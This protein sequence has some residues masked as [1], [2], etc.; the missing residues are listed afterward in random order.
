MYYV[1]KLKNKYKE[2]IGLSEIKY[3]KSKLSNDNIIEID[4]NN[5]NFKDYRKNI[6]SYYLSGNKLVRVSK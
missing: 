3:S 5:V 4:M 2:T 6:K 1:E